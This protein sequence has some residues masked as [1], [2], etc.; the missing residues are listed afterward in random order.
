MYNYNPNDLFRVDSF[1]RRLQFEY[2]FWSAD[3]LGV[4]AQGV[5]TLNGQVVNLALQNSSQASQN[6]LQLSADMEELLVRYRQGEL[7]KAE[8]E[9]QF[10][11]HARHIK[12]LAKRIRKDDYVRFVDPRKDLKSSKVATVRSLPEL[13]ALIDQLRQTTVDMQQNMSTFDDD[14][15]TVVSIGH[16]RQPSFR[17]LSRKISTLADAISRS[18]RR[19]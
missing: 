19:L 13:Q 17:S 16:L 11:G 7:S 6:I 9:E 14:Q 5:P 18:A 1:F 8:F 4:Y 12:Q 2:G 10:R 3:Y 15:T